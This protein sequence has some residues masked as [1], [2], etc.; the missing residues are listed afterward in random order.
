MDTVAG[1]TA[2]IVLSLLD[3]ATV[4]AVGAGAERV[5]VSGVEAPS[6]TTLV[7]GVMTLPAPWTVTV[8]VVSAMNVGTFAWITAEPSDTAVI[9]TEAVP[10]PGANVTV[11]GTVATD[12]VA[13]LRCTISP[14]A[15]AGAERLSVTF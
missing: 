11:D 8:V 6:D 2:A 9:G 5:T 1:D 12:G 14:P 10:A 4:S 13:E 3:S 15:G 7:V